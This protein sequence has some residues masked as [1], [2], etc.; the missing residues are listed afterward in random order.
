MDKYNNIQKETVNLKQ[1]NVVMDIYV[2]A[3]FTT[4]NIT[5]NTFP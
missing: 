3:N 5:L 1:V 2:Y 4:I